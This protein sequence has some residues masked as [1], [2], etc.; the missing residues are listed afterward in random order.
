MMLYLANIRWLHM[1]SLIVLVFFQAPQWSVVKR[2]VL[3]VAEATSLKMENQ[4][5]SGLLPSNDEAT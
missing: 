3:R 2:V 4:P 5:A 1:D